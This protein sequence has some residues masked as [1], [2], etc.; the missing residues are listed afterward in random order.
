MHGEKDP[1][2]IPDQRRFTRNACSSICVPFLSSDDRAT[3][4]RRMQN[5]PPLMHVEFGNSSHFAVL[6]V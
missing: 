1:S 5:M 2:C 3:L 4:L 6:H